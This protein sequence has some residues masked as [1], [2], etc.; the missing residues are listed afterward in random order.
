VIK[1]LIPRRKVSL[2]LSVFL[3]I[4]CGGGAAVAQ[5][6]LLAGG[7]YS[8]GVLTVVGPNGFSRTLYA[9][10][11][12]P[13][14]SNLGS[15]PDGEYTYQL[16]ATTNQAVRLATPQNDGRRSL[17]TVVRKGVATS[18]TFRVTGGAIAVAA[19]ASASTDN[20]DQD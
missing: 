1:A 12:A 19:A 3:A 7:P 16:S 11:G 4:A 5:S 18:G 6:S 14:L 8:N 17:T 13:A 10:N 15:L 9:K 2:A 20:D